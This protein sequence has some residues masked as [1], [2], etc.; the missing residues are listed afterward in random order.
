V[1][2]VYGAVQTL[3]GLVITPRIVGEK[4]G[5][6][7]VA[8]LLALMI[9]GELFGFLG[10]MLALPAAAVV[11]VFIGHALRRY[12]ESSLYDGHAPA[13]VVNDAPSSPVVSRLRW[14]RSPRARSQGAPR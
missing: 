8:V 14:R 2:A 6:P 12:R 4:L 5:L 7:A 10:V 9:G 1:V 11:K 13:A 3:E